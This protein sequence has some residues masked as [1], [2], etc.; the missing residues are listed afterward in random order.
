[1]SKAPNTVSKRKRSVCFLS[2]RI[3]LLYF[4]SNNAFPND[5]NVLIRTSFSVRP[6]VLLRKLGNQFVHFCVFHVSRLISG[7]TA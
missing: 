3:D 2:V 7:P 4:I 5:S 6:S 1:M